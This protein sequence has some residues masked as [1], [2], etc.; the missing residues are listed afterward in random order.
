[1]TILV[2]DDL[3][4]STDRFREK[5]ES[6]TDEWDIEVDRIITCHEPDQPDFAEDFEVLRDRQRSVRDGREPPPERTTI[7]DE[8]DI[9]FLDYHL[10]EKDSDLGVL[11]GEELAYYPRAFSSCGLL[12]SVNQILDPKF[13]LE[14]KDPPAPWSDLVISEDSLDSEGL[15]QPSGWEDFRPWL[16]PHL[17]TQV[18]SFYKAVADV[19]DNDGEALDE[20]LVEILGFSESIQKG[21]PQ[22]SIDYFEHEERFG[23]MELRSI[24]ASKL[25]AKDGRH[26]DL[27][28]D[29]WMAH[30]AV[31]IVSKWLLYDVLPRQSILTDAP[32]MVFRYP[33]LLCEDKEQE[34]PEDKDPYEECCR[35]DGR[36]PDSVYAGRVDDQFFEKWYWIGRPVWWMNALSSNQELY[37][38]SDQVD[39]HPSPYVFAEDA[40]AFFEEDECESWRIAPETP[41]KRR[42]IY[43]FQGPLYE[44]KSRLAA[45]TTS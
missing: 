7:F 19:V 34:P 20:R 11:S 25:K 38:V 4:E 30:F 22:E 24:G 44:P 36:L 5:I 23:E 21:I 8:S 9:V 28:P 6:A 35:L 37:E 39:S 32:H 12:V 3:P 1:M 33:S 2:H 45:G 43:H 16:W 10:D 31:S 41:H 26:A 14:M 42:Y 18:A 27:L 13:D 17:P 15:W 29:N 40:S